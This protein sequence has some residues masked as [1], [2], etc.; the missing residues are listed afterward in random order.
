VDYNNIEM[1]KL[2]TLNG[3]DNNVLEEI[4]NNDIIIYEDVQGSKIWVNW[5][6]QAFII[7]PKSISNEAINLVDLAMQNYYNSSIKFFNTFDNRI[8]GLMPKNW[9]FCFEYFPDNQPA[10]IEYNRVPKNG[11]VLAS[12]CKNGKYEYEI[13]ELREYSNLFGVDCL[14]VIFEGKLSDQMKE[15]IKYFLNTS[16]KDLEYVFGEK[17]FSFFFYKILNPVVENSFLMDNDFQKNLQKIVIKTKNSTSTFEI[18]NPLYQRISSEN[19]TEFIEVYTLILMN[20]LTFCQ[21]LNI[22]QLKIKGNRKDE[23]YL[24]L[25]CKL[26]NTY[27]SEVKDD[28]V[29]FDFVVPE[30]FDKE[31]FK[32]N[33]ELIPNKLTND[34]ISENDKLEYTFKVI[35][36]SFNKKRKKAIGIF[37]DNTIILFN[38]FVDKIDHLLDSHL[39]KLREIDITRGGLLDFGDFFEIKYDQDADGQVYPDVYD[40]FEKEPVSTKKKGGKFSLKK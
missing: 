16:E 23:A 32:I 27:I 28:I 21:S 4:L 25:I 1:S 2:V 18:L 33:K 35:L 36:G 14:P 24:Y 6:G 3:Q 5:N 11:L 30:F 39:N 29:N 15:A 9:W 17:S 20:F 37:T 13:D 34:I 38:G 12:I 40:T 22:D 7:K 10:N 19:S 8:R 31:K 26:F